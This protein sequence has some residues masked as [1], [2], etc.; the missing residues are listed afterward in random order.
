MAQPTTPQPREPGPGTP[1]D[2]ASQLCG[3]CTRLRPATTPW[4]D[5][6]LC[7]ARP[8][9]WLAMCEAAG[10]LYG[11]AHNPTTQGSPDQAPHRP[12]S[13]MHT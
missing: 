7:V 2:M 3:A 13:L 4:P 9:E 8:P 12:Q 5:T 6:H 10:R 11:T 1:P